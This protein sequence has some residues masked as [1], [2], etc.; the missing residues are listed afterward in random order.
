MDCGTFT[1]G[2]HRG[3]PACDVPVE[4]LSWCM[5]TMATPPQVVTDELRRRADRHGSRDAMAAQEA[6]GAFNYKRARK[7]A[8]RARKAPPSRPRNGGEFV[9][10][11]FAASRGQWIAAGGD[12][13]SCPFGD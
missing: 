13:L 1:F 11:E 4:Y 10:Q 7:E 6:L 12:P 9:G 5:A 3:L 8:R 2:K